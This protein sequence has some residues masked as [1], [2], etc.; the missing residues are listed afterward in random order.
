[1]SIGI[2]KITNLVNGKFYIGQSINIENRWKKHKQISNQENSPCYNYPLYRSIRKYGIDN[3]SFEIIEICE[4]KDLN[5][6]EI[7]WIYTLNS[8]N[9]NIGYNI[10]NGGNFSYPIKLSFE[11]VDLIINE[12]LKKEKTQQEIAEMFDVSQRMISSINL[13]QTW[14]RT[15][16]KYP[17]RE[18]PNLVEKKYCIDCGIE[19]SN[20]ANRC[21]KCNQFLNRKVERPSREELKNLIRNQSFL[22]IG[23]QF[24]VSDTA[25]RKWCKSENLPYKVK[26]IKQYSNEEWNKI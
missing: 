18:A 7:Y 19:I 24:G 1:M 26:E 3:F 16:L 12:I 20:T 4:K 8:T 23:K 10:C 9:K 17:L 14:R 2:Y 5:D 25:I 15:D 22:S 6:R 13:G 21:N 11:I